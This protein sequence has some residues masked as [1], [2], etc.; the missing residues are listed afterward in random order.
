MLF[1]RRQ[2]HRD[3]RHPAGQPWAGAASASSHMRMGGAAP[4]AWARLISGASLVSLFCL[5]RAR[6]GQCSAI[7]GKREAESLRLCCPSSARAPCLAWRAKLTAPKERAL[8]YL[9]SPDRIGCVT[10][11]RYQQPFSRSRSRWILP[12]A[13]L[14]SFPSPTRTWLSL[15]CPS[16]TCIIDKAIVRHFARRDRQQQQQRLNA[17]SGGFFW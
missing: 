15:S 16:A 11:V 2:G 10:P 6:A 12:I 7:D 13:V 5:C 9:A 4:A 3:G 1:L 14:Q 17:I 8:P